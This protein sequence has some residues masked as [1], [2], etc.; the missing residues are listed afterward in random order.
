[1]I[2]FTDLIALWVI[3]IKSLWSFA[4]VVCWDL[5]SLCSGTG[6]RRE[7]APATKTHISGY[8]LPSLPPPPHCAATQA[9]IWVNRARNAD[10]AVKTCERFVYSIVKITRLYVYQTCMADTFFSNS[11]GVQRFVGFFSWLCFL[12]ADWLGRQ[13][14]IT[15][16]V[17]VGSLHVNVSTFRFCLTDLP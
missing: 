2:G 1:M 17:L 7:G 5:S 6:G 11:R 16:Y 3:K 13:T 9:K 4:H 12:D 8:S 14:P 15:W 10:H